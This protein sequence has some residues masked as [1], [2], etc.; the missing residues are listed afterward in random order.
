MIGLSHKF[1]KNKPGDCSRSISRVMPSYGLYDSSSTMK[2]T[3]KAMDASREEIDLELQ[4]H[5]KLFFK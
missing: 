2:S 1:A 4:N 3:R 5:D